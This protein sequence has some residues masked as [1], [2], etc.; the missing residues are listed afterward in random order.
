MSFLGH[1]VDPRRPVAPASPSRPQAVSPFFATQENPSARPPLI[2]FG[3]DTRNYLS[4]ASRTTITVITRTLFENAGIAKLPW[5]IASLVGYLSPQA[6]SGDEEW[7]AMAEKRFRETALSPRVYDAGGRFNFFTGQIFS[8]FRELTDGDFYSIFTKTTS[9]AARIAMREGHQV[10]NPSGARN[11]EWV[12]GIRVDDNTFPLAY[13]FRTRWNAPDRILSSSAVHQHINF[14]SPSSP[15]APGALAH[16]LNDFRDIIVTKSFQKQAIMMAAQMG[17]SRKQDPGNGKVPSAAGLAAALA[18]DVY[19]P[20]SLVASG[21][22]EPEK[23]IKVEDILGGGV[24]SQVPLDVLHDDRPHPNG[25]AFKESLMKEACIGLGVPPSIGYFLRDNSGPEINTDLEIFARYI[26]NRHLF[27]NL[28]F[29]QRFW[30]YSIALDITNGILPF[31]KTGEFWNVRWLPQRSVTSNLSKM[32]STIERMIKSNLM[33][34]EDHFA[35]LGQYGPDQLRTIAREKAYLIKLE[36]EFEL[37]AGT[38]LNGSLSTPA[39]QAQ[40]PA[41]PATDEEEDPPVPKK[42]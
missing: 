31:P 9:G 28:P 39:L 34:Y 2:T 38:M 20:P 41:E 23:T 26:I 3:T 24:F 16:A 18:T 11:E 14:V 42:K 35:A 30:T 32:A 15:R 25:E 10:V 29:C 17:L 6:N 40:T 33:S 12:D 13:N 1:P 21:K 8:T 7:D 37:P 36:K 5:N 4:P 22:A 27:H 19:R